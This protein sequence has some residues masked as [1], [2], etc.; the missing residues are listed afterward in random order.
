[1]IV[2][3]SSS[4]GQYGTQCQRSNGSQTSLT[5]SLN[6]PAIQLARLQG[7]SPIIATSS[8]KHTDWLKSLGATHVIDRS[9]SPTDILAELPKLTG[10]KPIVYAFDT[11]AGPETQHMTYDALAPGGSMVL[12]L[13]ATGHILAE[14]EKRDAGSKKV[15]RPYASLQMPGNVKLG[16]ELYARLTEWLEKGL[17]VVR[18]RLA[19]LVVVFVSG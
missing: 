4:V 5:P 18:R 3:G 1:M 11:V 2:G 15:A 13:P 6:H 16:V 7:F 14:K 12:T 9:L 10:G 17:L 19:A 8:L